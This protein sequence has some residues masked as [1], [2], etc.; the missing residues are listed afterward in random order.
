MDNPHGRSSSSAAKFIPTTIK[1]STDNP[2]IKQ[3]SDPTSLKR[4]AKMLAIEQAAEPPEE[5]S[6]PERT[7]KGIPLDEARSKTYWFRRNIGYIK[8]CTLYTSDAA[9]DITRVDLGDP[10]RHKKKKM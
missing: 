5:T 10:S 3:V 4:K 2:V 8:T 7:E 6:S 1:L 9:D